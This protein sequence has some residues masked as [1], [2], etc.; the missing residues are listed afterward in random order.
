MDTLKRIGC[1]LRDCIELYLPILSFIILFCVFVAGIVARYII[2]T[3][4]VWSNE[5]ISICFLWMVLSAA[6]YCQHHRSHVTFT[7]VYDALPRRAAEFTAFL[8]NAIILAA[9][10][11]SF[12][13]TLKYIQFMEVQKSSMLRIPMSIIYIPY[14]FFMAFLMVYMVIEMV[15]QFLIFTG[16]DRKFKKHE[17]EQVGSEEEGGR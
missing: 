7:M 2:K 13:P 12:L 5:V 11:L 10:A 16:L 6:C 8:G 14:I 4:I 15:E 3:P 17:P 9:L 1:F